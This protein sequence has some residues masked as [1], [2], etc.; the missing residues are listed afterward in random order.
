MLDVFDVENSL[1]DQVVSYMIE[2]EEPILN[3]IIVEEPMLSVADSLVNTIPAEGEG[4]GVLFL[5]SSH[6]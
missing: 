2:N 4:E 1:V 5:L 3:V 6:L